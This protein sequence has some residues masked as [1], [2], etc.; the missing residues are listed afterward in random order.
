MYKLSNTYAKIRVPAG[1]LVYALFILLLVTILSG[2]LIVFTYYNKIFSYRLVLQSQVED[3]MNS[4]VNFYTSEYYSDSSNM[5]NYDFLDS[6]NIQNKK[7]GLFEIVK[8]ESRQKQLSNTMYYLSGKIGRKTDQ[9]ALY[10]TDLGFGLNLSG[11][12]VIRGSVSIPN[13]KFKNSVINTSENKSKPFIN[14]VLHTSSSK[15]VELNERYLNESISFML[16]STKEDSIVYFNSIMDS[17]LYNSFFNK[18]LK[19]SSDKDIS[20]INKSIKGRV[21][22]ISSKSITLDST[23]TLE[24]VLLF[25]PSVTVKSNFKGQ[26]QIIA[27]D[28]I[29]ISDNCNFLYPSILCI[30]NEKSSSKLIIGRN[31]SIRGSVILNVKNRSKSSKLV[32]SKS[33]LIYGE[34]VCTGVFEFYGEVIGS[35]YTNILGFDSSTSYYQ[36]YLNNIKIDR[37]LLSQ[38]YVFSNILKRNSQRAIIKCLK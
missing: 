4:G 14:G 18:T 3:K 23:S 15:F 33:S 37:L 24:D 35:V 32:L 21:I 13:G 7:W 19:L 38:H 34:V 12:T 26:C 2:S 20:L 31:C 1:S 27:D 22:V 16:S 6:V 17:E 11:N 9:L 36:N 5:L 30:S 29:I 28:S 8:I 10:L 25:A